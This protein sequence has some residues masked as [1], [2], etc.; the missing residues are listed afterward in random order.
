MPVKANR[1][2][3]NRDLMNKR[4]HKGDKLLVGS[5]RIA[6]ALG[7]N[8]FTLRYRLR[9]RYTILRYMFRMKH[10]GYWAA[11]SSDLK[12]FRRTENY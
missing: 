2:V 6:K 9:N 8:V 10:N 11:W 5:R 4:R 3:G 12:R 1:V 7:W